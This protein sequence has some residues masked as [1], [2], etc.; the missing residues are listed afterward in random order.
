ME[1]TKLFPTKIREYRYEGCQGRGTNYAYL[2]LSPIYNGM[3][4]VKLTPPIGST[5]ANDSI[6]GM[7]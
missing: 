5:L 7:N 4:G 2:H 1:T 6:I 3:S